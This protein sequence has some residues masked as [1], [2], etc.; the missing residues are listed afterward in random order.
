[1]LVSCSKK[2]VVVVRVPDK[3]EQSANIGAP[4]NSQLASQPC[5]TAHSLDPTPA[6]RELREGGRHSEVGVKLAGGGSFEGVG[7]LS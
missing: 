4:S 1:M 5:T 7:N 6:T 3:E 2:S